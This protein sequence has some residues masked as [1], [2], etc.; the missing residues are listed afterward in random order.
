M[1]KDQSSHR[2]ILKKE[3]AEKEKLTKEKIILAELAGIEAEMTIVRL[4]QL[5]IDYKVNRL[6]ILIKSDE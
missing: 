4:S 6:K 2:T 3:T 1:K 5:S